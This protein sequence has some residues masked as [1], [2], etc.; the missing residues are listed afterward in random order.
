MANPGDAT[1]TVGTQQMVPIMELRST[2]SEM[3][4]AELRDGGRDDG[5]EAPPKTNGTLLIRQR[6]FLPL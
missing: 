3:V 5:R 2:I 4:I 1:G 6:S